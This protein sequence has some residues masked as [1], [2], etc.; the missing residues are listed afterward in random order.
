Q[1][2][3]HA[4]LADVSSGKRRQIGSRHHRHDR[5]LKPRVRPVVHRPAENLAR[6]VDRHACQC[7]T[8]MTSVSAI[9]TVTVVHATALNQRELTWSP[10]SSRSFVS[11]SMKIRT[12]GRTM[13]LTTWDST[14]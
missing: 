9:I 2:E 1:I 7:R 11:S 6:I 10:I 5:D 13:P 14:R 12:K 8:I 4:V 3:N